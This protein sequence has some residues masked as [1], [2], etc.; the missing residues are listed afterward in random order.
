[1]D[2]RASPDPVEK[3]N[4][5]ASAGNR[6]PTLP[7]RLVHS[8]D[9][10]RAELSRLLHDISK[11][12]SKCRD[13]QYRTSERKPSAG[14]GHGALTSRARQSVA[15]SHLSAQLGAL[16]LRGP[17]NKQP[18]RDTACELGAPRENHLSTFQHSICT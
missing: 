8:L 18:L 13:S 7:G 6:I 12:R 9:N 1:V 10:T 15:R 2:R 4:I 11:Y 16:S 3:R 17:T 14:S 5:S